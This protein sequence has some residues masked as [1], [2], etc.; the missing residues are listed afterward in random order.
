[1]AISCIII[2]ISAKSLKSGGIS[3]SLKRLVQTVRFFSDCDCDSSYRNK[4]VAQDSMEM[5]TL[6]DCNNMTNSYVAHYKQKN[7]LLSQSEKIGP[8]DLC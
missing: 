1:M 6:C 8:W 7:K 4:W 3:A 5:F 2:G